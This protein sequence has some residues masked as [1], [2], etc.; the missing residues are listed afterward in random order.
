MT[1]KIKHFLKLSFVFLIS[2]TLSP[3]LVFISLLIL[4]FDGR[5]IF[6]NQTRLGLKRK[7][8]LIY[9]FKTMEAEKITF[10][11]RWLRATGIDELPQ[12]INVLKSEMNVV[13]PRPLTNQEVLRMEWATSEYDSRWEVRPGITGLAQLSKECNKNLTWKN[14]SYYVEHKSFVLNLKIICLSFFMMIF[15]KNIIKKL[16]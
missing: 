11:G 8:F 2:V 14:D 7:E 6:F 10:L 9:K 4:F 15:G 12:F 3:L 1:E 16:L 5:P 13:G